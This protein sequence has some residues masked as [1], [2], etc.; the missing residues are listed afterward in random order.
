MKTLLRAPNHGLGAGR[1]G[2]R[3][4]DVTPKNETNKYL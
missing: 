1:R 3:E 4:T 2:D